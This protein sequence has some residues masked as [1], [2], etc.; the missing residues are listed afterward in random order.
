MLARRP[1]GTRRTRVACSD[2]LGRFRRAAPG[3]HGSLVRA[4]GDRRQAPGRAVHRGQRRTI[5]VRCSRPGSRGHPARG[6]E[7][8][9]RR[10]GSRPPRPRGSGAAP[11]A[12]GTASEPRVGEPP[13]WNASTA[14]RAAPA[15]R[16][17][18]APPP[19]RHRRCRRSSDPGAGDAQT[20]P[21]PERHDHRRPPPRAC[22]MRAA[23]RRGMRSRWWSRRPRGP[24][25]G[26][27]TRAGHAAS[28]APRRGMSPNLRPERLG[29]RVGC[30][31]RRAASTA[32]AR[33][34][35]ATHAPRRGSPPPA[36]PRRSA[37]DRGSWRQPL[38]DAEPGSA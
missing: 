13:W 26:R 3:G 22:P 10:P 17:A 21:R 4:A 30:V 35:P 20:L 11:S 27:G 28:G 18:G 5:S 1:P 8:R 9:P 25:T 15:A 14:D 31:G 34:D 16:R 19:D 38:V 12:A 6:G 33:I 24:A 37:H 23:A 36:R 7:Q 29:Q 2:P 32:P